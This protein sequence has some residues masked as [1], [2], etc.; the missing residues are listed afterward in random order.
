MLIKWRDFSSLRG[1]ASEISAQ[2]YFRDREV[3]ELFLGIILDEKS[4]AA[5]KKNPKIFSTFIKKML[6]FSIFNFG[7]IACPA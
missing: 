5:L 1:G 4:D 2:L 6:W 3:N 7:P